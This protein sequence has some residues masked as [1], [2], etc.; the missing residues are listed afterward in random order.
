MREAPFGLNEH[1]RSYMFNDNDRYKNPKKTILE[2]PKLED[3][4]EKSD[5][6]DRCK[7]EFG[8][9]WKLAQS[10]FRPLG[11]WSTHAN[12]FSSSFFMPMWEKKWKSDHGSFWEALLKDQKCLMGET[13][14][15]PFVCVKISGIC[16]Q[17]LCI[18][19][20]KKILQ[21]QQKCQMAVHYSFDSFFVIENK[22]KEN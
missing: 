3:I 2:S 1:K 8:T 6:R 13:K 4:P 17:I 12:Y 10:L 22:T 18:A 7:I 9:S 20:R 14:W 15:V 16:S 11:N 5:W 21:L 19:L